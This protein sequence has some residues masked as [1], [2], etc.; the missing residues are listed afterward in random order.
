MTASDVTVSDQRAETWKPIPGFSKYEASDLGRIRS[1]ATGK[2][3][4]TRVSN[5]GYLLVKPYDDD[6]KQQ[7]RT[8]HTLIL[9]TFVGPPSPGM[10]TL[11]GK[12]GP[13]DNR[14]PENIRYGTK[15]QNADDITAAGTRKT[16]ATYPCVN[17][18]RCGGM[19][20]NP[21]RR[22]LP[23]VMEVGGEAAAMLNAG[24]PLD[25]VAQRLGYQNVEWVY[26][27]AV[28]HGGYSEPITHARSQR[29]PWRRRVMATIRD[30]LTIRER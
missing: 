5:S 15:K 22:C 10:E 23:C 2:M 9:L 24:T 13:L 16:P 4:A 25:A 18:E 14:W 19:T 11:H 20:V 29:Q 21:G 27:L 1:A 26:R 6:G 7:T 12:G 8:V 17:H 30:R 3:L 28:K